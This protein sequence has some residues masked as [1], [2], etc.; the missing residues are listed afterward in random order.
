M[1]IAWLPAYILKEFFLSFKMKK[2]AR[3]SFTDHST[4]YK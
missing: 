2:N 3:T 1:T 4:V